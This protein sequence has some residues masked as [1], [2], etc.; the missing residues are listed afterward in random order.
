TRLRAI[1]GVVD[2]ALANSLP[3]DG[4]NW[5]SVFVVKDKP[6]PP[7]AEL[8]S[9]AFTPVS[10][11]LFQTLQMR[12]KQGRLFDA[13]DRESSPRVAIINETLARQLWPNESPIGKQLKQGWPETPPD[14]SP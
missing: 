10:A 7:R 4:S 14:V 9:A 12:L 6:A 8:P 3:I 1:P 5:N 11:R 2:A 13:T